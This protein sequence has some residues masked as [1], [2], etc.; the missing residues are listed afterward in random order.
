VLN[1]QASSDRAIVAINEKIRT[2]KR[3]H[4]TMLPIA[5]GVYMVRRV[6]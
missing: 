6:V 2:D 1:P 4:A 5:D 3:V